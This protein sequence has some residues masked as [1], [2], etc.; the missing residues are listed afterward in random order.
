MPRDLGGDVLGSPSISA[1]VTGIVI[2]F[3]SRSTFTLTFCPGFV[4]AT[5]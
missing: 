2:S 3:P 4:P 1:T 5:I